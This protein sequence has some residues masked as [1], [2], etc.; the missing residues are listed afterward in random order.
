MF[1]ILGLALTLSAQEENV[2]LYENFDDVPTGD[3]P[4]DWNI[5]DVG[6]IEVDEFPSKTNKSLHLVDKGSGAG[7]RLMFETPESDVFSV[8]YKFYR[9]KSSG[10]DVE[11]VYVEKL[12]EGQAVQFNGCCVAMHPGGSITYNDGGTWKEGPDIEDKKWHDFKYI[13]NQGK[14]WAFYFDKKKV[15]GIGFRAGVDKEFNTL[16]LLNYLN[17][18]TTLDVYL[19]ELMVYEGTERPIQPVEK[20]GKLAT[21]W[22]ILKADSEVHPPAHELEDF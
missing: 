18:G 17:G 2:I 20:K 4:E 19:D 3:V 8:E 1:F 13:I 7:A 21:T 16:L 14:D 9:K 5:T 12:A 6:T 22:G 10:G 11:I 15:E